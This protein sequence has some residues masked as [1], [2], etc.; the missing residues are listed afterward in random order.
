VKK[1]G[2]KHEDSPEPEPAMSLLSGQLPAGSARGSRKIQT[3]AGRYLRAAARNEPP[4][5]YGTPTDAVDDAARRVWEIA[6]GLAVRRRVDA[7]SPLAEISRTV[8]TAVHDHAAA[9]LP[10]LDAEMLVRDALGEPVPTDGIDPE[11][12]IGVHLLVFASLTDELALGDGELDGLIAEAEAG[13]VPAA[14]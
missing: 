4:A 7:D 10:L 11:V 1:K 14:G 13:P 12:L 8:A 3:E 9:A 6:F 5:R 2:R